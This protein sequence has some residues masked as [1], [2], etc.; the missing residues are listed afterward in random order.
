MCLLQCQCCIHTQSLR[1]R[2]IIYIGNKLAGNGNTPTTIDVLGPR[3]E[4]EGYTL[5]YASDR[6]NIIFRLLHMLY[7]IV[8]HAR[9]ADLVLVDASCSAEAVARVSPVRSLIHKVKIVYQTPTV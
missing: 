5:Y 9:K 1:N 2:T 6:A 4:I 7:S 3:L 8:K